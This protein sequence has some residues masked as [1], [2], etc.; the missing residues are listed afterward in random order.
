MWE[1]KEI[2]ARIRKTQLFNSQ[3]KQDIIWYFDFLTE[4]QKKNLLQALDTETIIIKNFLTSLK[5]KDI[6]KFEEIKNN[7][8]TIQMNERKLQE[9]KE[10]EKSKSEIENLLHNLESI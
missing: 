10:E 2:I 7:I 1:K 9:L 6:I 3:L 8:E 4:I 5:D